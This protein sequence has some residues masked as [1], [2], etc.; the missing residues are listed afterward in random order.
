MWLPGRCGR[1]GPSAILSADA[2]R[3][4]PLVRACATN[5]WQCRTL[6]PW[7]VVLLFHE[8]AT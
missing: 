4:P 3:R 6:T 2:D 5:G 1:P 7:V 8:S